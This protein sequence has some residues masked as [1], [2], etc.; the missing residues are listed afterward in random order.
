MQRILPGLL[1]LILVC[2]GASTSP[3]AQT[4]QAP[5][6]NPQ[7][8]TE[9]ITYYM[10]LLRRG[11]AWTAAVTP[12]TSAVSRGHMENI[13]RL[14]TLGKMVV[15]VPFLEQTGERALTGL[16]IL[17]VESA[18]EARALVESDPAVKA[19][20]FVYELLPWL[21]PATLRH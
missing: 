16:F 21:G 14:T 3:L 13:Q 18:A 4:P 17:R 6:I 5:V 10:V 19:G 20:R 1:L 9:M 11:P 7:T 15:A 2:G 8:G 12:E